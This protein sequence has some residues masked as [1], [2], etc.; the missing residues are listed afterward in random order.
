MRGRRSLQGDP[1]R[2]RTAARVGVQALQRGADERQDVALVEAGG[3]VDH[4][5]R[6]ARAVEMQ[7]LDFDDAAVVDGHAHRALR[8]G[9][10]DRAS[11]QVS[12]IDDP[13]VGA[14]DFGGV[15]V[16]ERPVIVAKA[17]EIF[18]RARRVAFVAGA[19]YVERGVQ[20]P[21]IEPAFATRG[22]AP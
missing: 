3:D 2:N 18:Y 14:D 7:R 5:V 9:L 12:G 8:A 16:A 6:P 21:D 11:L 22:I 17:L 13:G 10:A 1:D 15:D 19:R 20:Q 4:L